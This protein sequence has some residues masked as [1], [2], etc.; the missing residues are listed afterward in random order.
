MIVSQ[1]L[2]QDNL[3]LL[4]TILE[5]STFEV[6]PCVYLPDY[7]WMVSG[8][9]LVCLCKCIDACSGWIFRPLILLFS[10]V[11]KCNSTI[12]GLRKTSFHFT[13]YNEQCLLILKRCLFFQMVRSNAIIVLTDMAK[14]FPNLIEPWTPHL[15]ARLRDSSITVRNMTVAVLT[16]LILHDMVKVSG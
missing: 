8:N 15:Y 5:R 1:S 4:F 13:S 6:S 3:Q 2:C 9:I 14:R 11:C 12:A 16:H 7:W 10:H